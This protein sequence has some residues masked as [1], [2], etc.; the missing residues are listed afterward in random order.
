MRLRIAL[1]M[2]LFALLASAHATAAPA[3]P[4]ATLAEDAIPTVRFATFNASLNRN[5]AGQLV[6][7]LSAPGN[8]QAATVAEIIQRVRPDVLLINEFD[9]V[10]GGQAA[11]LFQQNYLGVSHNGTE[12][13]TYTYRYVAPS[14][15]GIAT[16]FDLNN[17]GTAVITPG[18]PGYGDDAFGFGAFPGQF[19]MA[20]YS[21]YEI[22]E[23]QIRTFQKFLWKD[24]PGALLP[25]N[26]ATGQPW[27]SAEELAVFRLSSKSHWD[28]PINV[29]GRIIHF[30]V[31]HPT[32]PVFDGTEDRNGKRNHDEIRFWA[33]YI[34][35]GEGDYIYD[36]AGGKGGLKPGASFVIAGDQNADPFDGDSVAFAI[37]QLLDNPLVNTSV[38]PRSQGAVEQSFLQGNAN[39]RHN[40]NPA[41]DTADFS[42]STPGNLRADYVLPAH[43]LNIV[44]AQ[45]YWPVS[46]DPNFGLVGTFNS[47]LP[48]GFPSSDHRLVYVDVAL[49]TVNAKY[50][51]P[52]VLDTDEDRPADVPLG[53]ADDPAIYVHPTDPA[54]SFFL[55]V[56][57]DGGIA[58]YDL[59]GKQLQLLA[60]PDI[61][62]NNVD[63]QYSFP[64][65]NNL[66]IDFA[67]ATD[68]RND[69]MVFFKIDP[70]TRTITDI[71]APN[72]PRVFT[73]GDDDA[74]EEQT[75]AYGIALYRSPF[76]AGKYYVFVSKRSADTVVQLEINA[77]T[78]GKLATREVR[79]FTLPVP[80]GG[81]LEDAQIEGMVADQELGV[82]YIAQENVGIWKIGAEANSGTTATL[83]YEVYPE[84]GIL[85]A[86]A[87]GLT[88]YYGKDGAG[89]L[90]ASSQ[91]DNTFAV[92][93]RQAPNTYL[94]SFQIAPQGEVDGVQEC[95]G[96]DVINLPLGPDFPSGLFV[97]QDGL[98]D[99]EV[100]RE[101][102]GELENVSTSFKLT[103]WADIAGAFLSDL[104]IDTTSYN[105][106]QPQTDLA[107]PPSF[108]VLLPLIR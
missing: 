16:G 18:Q 8:A 28:L 56:L 101:D 91:G 82:L 43:Y 108:K 73:E 27:Y 30:L 34:T 65:S 19:G 4:A 100:L 7:D 79:R 89:Y 51:T 32:P 36:D 87:E 78:D 40:G 29:E 59:Q 21:Q 44:D 58:V 35:P 70:A 69:K 86:D 63:L 33:D 60:P 20:V 81:E 47:S 74:L 72:L 17:N 6:T 84:G 106:R 13:I 25:T 15:T 14:N 98:N 53:D 80:A 46:S 92:F 67:A 103:S 3:Q 94:G 9:Y 37:N 23:E 102:D 54:Q 42:D 22:D 26:P 24:M 99:P 50:E 12:P 45:V 107:E 49:P 76:Y 95:D 90:L 97:T 105:P 5:A 88:I 1:F 57:K 52:Q 55:G 41:F 64:L 38:T 66:S 75:T 48:G 10:E 2:A 11:Q 83:L 71:T 96:A 39:S 61:R 93:D 62:Y 77:T 104:T 31:S 68:R 85:Q